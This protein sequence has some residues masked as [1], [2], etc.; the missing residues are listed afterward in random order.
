MWMCVA[1]EWE[2]LLFM[3]FVQLFYCLPISM[4]ESVFEWLFACV[5]VW[6]QRRKWKINKLF[7]R[8]NKL[9]LL[10]LCAKVFDTEYIQIHVWW[11]KVC[12]LAKVHTPHIHALHTKPLNF[13][14]MPIC[15]PK[16]NNHPQSNGLICPNS[17]FLFWPEIPISMVLFLFV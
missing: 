13:F 10:C 2:S 15:S 11:I 6:I 5:C 8:T 12:L 9:C 7:K 1:M 4:S 3:D 16:L 14:E 17:D